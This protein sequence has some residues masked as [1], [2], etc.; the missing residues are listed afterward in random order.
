VQQSL[1]W[2]VDNT[3]AI[4][5]WRATLLRVMNFRQALL[6]L[7]HFEMGTERF[8]RDTNT[9]GHIV[10]DDLAIMN[11]RGRS[12]LSET[13]VEIK[14]GERVLFAGEPG[15]GK[16]T[17]FLSIAGLWD[18]GSGRI[19]LPSQPDIMFLAQRPY[20]P[21]GALRDVLIHSDDENPAGDDQLAAALKRVGLDH[22]ALSLDRVERWDTELSAREQQRLALARLVI[23]RPKWIVSDEALDLADD[24]NREIVQSIFAKELAD[25]AVVSIGSNSRKNGFYARCIKLIPLPVTGQSGVDSSESRR[26]PEGASPES[27]SS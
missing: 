8:Q 4:A 9:E 26:E 17:L 13:H 19:S 11:P 1:R 27:K 2:F 18:W 22:L 3:G 12:E 16:S 21:P 24:S 25:T 7:D 14:P 5:D 15:A 23:D 20:V 10:F 6:D